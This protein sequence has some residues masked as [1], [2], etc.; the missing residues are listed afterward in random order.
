MD[1]QTLTITDALDSM[2]LGEFT[3]QDLAEACFN[4]INRLNPTLNAYITIIDP[5]DALNAQQAPLNT[6]ALYRALR[7]IPI[8]VK[9]LFDV[10]GTPTTIGS[11]FFGENIADQDAFVVE[12][13]THMRSH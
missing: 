2:G 8:A 12:K 10:E 4:Q 3:P 7:G 5:Q 9:D 6:A 13:P 1:T 11:K